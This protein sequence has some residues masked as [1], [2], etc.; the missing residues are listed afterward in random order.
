MPA[1]RKQRRVRLEK[2]AD[3]IARHK[4]V[5]WGRFALRAS[6]IAIAIAAGALFVR[7]LDLTPD[8]SHLDVSILSGSPEGHYHSIVARL[9]IAAAEEEGA[10]SNVTTQGSRANLERLVA[11]R[12]DCDVQLGL[13]QDGFD[14][15]LYQGLEAIGRVGRPEAV[16]LL[17]RNGDAIQ[18]VADLQGLRIGIGPEGSGSAFLAERLLGA[19]ELSS[20]ELTLE[21]YS[22]KRQMELAASGSL[23]LAFF[24]MDEDAELLAE[25]IRV[26]GLQIVGLTHSEALA[27]RFPFVQYGF[28]HA[29]QYDPVRVL[30]PV[31]KP[32]LRLDTLLLSNGC[33][34]HSDIIALMTL[35]ARVY[36]GFIDQNRSMTV[37]A[38][39][40]LSESARGF[41]ENDGAA[42]TDEYVPWLV[43]IMPPSNWVYT[44]M[45]V[46]LFFNLA[47][48]LNN[49][50]LALIDLNR[51]ALEND[52]AILFGD[53]V[54]NDEIRHFDTTKAG[55]RIDV[56]ELDRLIDA[57]KRH[58]NKARRQS[59]SVF[60]PMG[61]EMGYRDQEIIM[62]AT[63]DALRELRERLEQGG[64]PV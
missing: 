13:V 27:R 36:P 43:D 4:H 34:G 15:S 53:S 41:Y 56:Q 40:T 32:I 10:V 48:F 44:V 24:V 45:A 39:L 28:L 51:V 57:Y 16:M 61:E 6:V 46:S 1:S 63:L 12:Q 37:P 9:A 55:R 25:A 29:G 52:I 35:L 14:R 11:A 47:G 7:T 3:V 2:T 49:Q 31:A 64:P 22:L 18:K 50:R 17:G 38:G 26:R 5:L 21:H 60:S 8:M 20:L 62:T 23:D 30:P 33:A 59:L 54:S 19:A 42:L 58:L